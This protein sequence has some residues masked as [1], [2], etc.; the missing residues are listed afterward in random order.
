MHVRSA[1][2]AFCASIFLAACSGGGGGGTTSAASSN[3]DSG[4][5]VVSGVFDPLPSPLAAVAP[6]DGIWNYSVATDYYYGSKKGGAA[7]SL[8]YDIKTNKLAQKFNY[9]FPVFGS[10]DQGNSKLNYPNSVQL[11]CYDSKGNAT[12]QMVFSYFALPQVHPN[13]TTAPAAYLGDCV[14]GNLVTDYYK[15]TVGIPRV[16]PILEMSAGFNA[17][18]VYKQTSANA[19]QLGADELVVLAKNIATTILNDPNVY[20]VGFDNE[21][22]IFKAAGDPN[23]PGN[24]NCQ[25]LDLEHLF[26]GTLAHALA[27]DKVNGPKYL[28]LFDA[29]ATASALYTGATTVGYSDKSGSYTCTYSTTTLTKANAFQALP[30][31]VV[32]PALYDMETISDSGPLVVANYQTDVNNTVQ[33]ALAVSTDPP[34]M[35]VLPASATDTMWTSVQTYNL[36]FKSTPY[37]PPTQLPAIGV[38]NNEATIS[39]SISYGV[40]AALICGPDGLGCPDSKTPNLPADNIKNFLSQC[41]VYPNIYKGNNVAMNDYFK[42]ALNAVSAK[43]TPANKARYLGVSLYAWRIAETSDINGAINYYSVYSD[44]SIHKTS[45]QLFPME[46]SPDIWTSFLGWS[47]PLKL[48]K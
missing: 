35:L 48:G 39:T 44:P 30:N 34:A 14:N 17:A 40:L 6:G 10:L 5:L 16:V 13:V 1:S 25:G 7:P 24:V 33:S 32:K 3:L 18:L 28:F 8:V 46:I 22:A 4:K 15:N 41:K 11:N 45:I 19:W 47:N 38:C 36:N 20:G 31:I 43:V 2:V 9:V 29:P 23:N 21:P 42:A 26:Y 12:P 37:Y 27:S